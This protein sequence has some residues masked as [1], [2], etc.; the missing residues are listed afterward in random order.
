MSSSH[1]DAVGGVCDAVAAVLL[2]PPPQALDS[3]TPCSGFDLRALVEHF[4]GTS[5]ALARLG[6]DR[7]L[8]P[9]DPWGGGAGSAE[10]DWAALLRGNLADL[11]RGWG[12]PE[13]WSGEAQVGG[14]RLPRAMLGEMALVEVAA[15]GWDV[16]RALGR[17]LELPPPAAERVEQAV[18]ATAVLGRQMGAY[19]PEME[20]PADAPALDRALAQ[21][22]RDPRWSPAG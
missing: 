9:D 22:G 15:H 13:A 19:G 1:P 5:G 11:A 12:R 10:G 16:A 2:D 4:V 21:A 3:P 20:V 6:L 8:D 14:S 18:A 17:T 7:P